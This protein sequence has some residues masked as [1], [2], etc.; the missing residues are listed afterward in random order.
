MTARIWGDF[1]AVLIEEQTVDSLPGGPVQLDSEL[2]G[3]IARVKKA[4]GMQTVEERWRNRYFGSYSDLDRRDA[5]FR[6]HS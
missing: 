1:A 2:V 4:G 3:V 5:F 6:S